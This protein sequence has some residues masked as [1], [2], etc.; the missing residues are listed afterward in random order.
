MNL[1]KTIT[2]DL[3]ARG[4][5]IQLGDSAVSG[6]CGSRALVF[7]LMEE[8]KPWSVPAGTRAGLAFRTEYGA[9]GE[10]D[11]MPDGSEAWLIE[12][13]RVT[14]RLVDAI[15]ARP[16][17]VWLA[18]VLRDEGF[19][20]LS[21]FPVVM[22]VARGLEDVGEIPRNY[23][24]VR[25][26]QEIN[27]AIQA[28]KERVEQVD[29]EEN[30]A[31]SR[32]ARQAVEEAKAYAASVNGEL[33]QA[34]INAKGDDVYVEN[35]RLYLTSNGARLGVGV[36]LP[37]GGGVGFASW[38]YDTETM[39][40]HAR[41]EE[42][43]DVLEPVYI[44]GGSGGGDSGS[45][46]TVAMETS[47]SVIAAETAD[48][49]ELAFSF[50]SVDASTGVATG[51]GTM[52]ISVGGV[53]KKTQQIG[54]GRVSLNIRP[55]LSAGA[56]AV[57]LT[58]TDAYGGRAARNI[59][60]TLETL[61]LEWS[62]GATAKTDDTLTVYLTA[63]GNYTKT[64]HL[65]VDGNDIEVFDVTT[66]GRRVTKTV[67]AQ[68]H[69]G[70]IISAYATMEAAGTTMTSD[71][72]Q[73]ACAWVVDEIVPAI[74]CADVPETADQF[75]TVQLVHRVVDPRNNPAAVQYLVNGVLFK[76]AVI[77]QS[78]QIWSYR[79]N[80]AGETTLSILCGNI[81]HDEVIQVTQLAAGVEEVTD[82]LALKID[83]AAMADL[84]TWEENGYRFA[85]SEGF[86][87]VNG[88]L[89]ND[90]DGVRCIRVTAGDRLKLNY[91]LFATDA[92]ANGLA[93]KL[94]YAVRDSSAKHCTAISCVS[95][96]MGLEIQ[97]NN[98]YLRGNQT[99]C[100]LSVCED[101]KTEL[102]FNIQT[103]TNDGIMYLWEKCSTFAYMKYAADESFTFGG[104]GITFGCD[105]ADV[106]LYLARFYTRDLTD[107][108]RLANYIADGANTAEILDRR[109]RNDIYDS[110]GSIDV[111]KCAAKNP[112]CH[113]I[114][115]SAER[116]TKGKKDEVKANFRHIFK[117][118]GAEHQW[119]ASGSMFVQGTSS[120]EHAET[121]GP[122]LNIYYPD[123]ITLADGT[124]VADGY[125]MNG[126]DK[127]IPVLELC[128]KKNIA[129]E[130]HIVNRMSAEWYNRYQPS[131]R[132]ERAAN[133]LVRDCLDSAM[134]CVYF[135]NS[136]S[137]AVQVGPDLV[138][139]GATIFFGLGNLVSNKD[140]VQAFGYHPIVI[141][142]KNNTEPQVL[143]KSTDLEGSNWGNNYEFRYLDTTKYTEDE[144]KAEWQKVQNF[145][146]ETDCT[147]ATDLPLAEPVT[148]GG[149]A[150]VRDDVK[151]RRARWE[152]ESP[153]IFDK[154]TLTWHHN[155]TLF[156]LL[157]D[158]R[159]K[160]MFWSKDPVTGRWGLWFNWDNDTGLCRNNDGYVDIEPG[161]MDFDTIGTGDVFN[162]A[163]NVVFNNLR[164]WDFAELKAD[165]LDRESA[166][167]WDIDGLYSYAM[168]SQESICEALWIEDAAHN[169]VR[170]MQA[171]GTTAY[172]ERATGRLR[173]HLKKALTFQKVLVDSYY[174]STAATG[175]SAA[176]RGY[177][178]SEWAGVEP[179]G[180]LCVTAYTN[181]YVNVLAG[182]TAYQVRATE[183]VPVE[184]DISASLNN[185]EVYFRHAEWM[186]DLGDLAGLYLG[187][188]EASMLKRVRRLSIGSDNVDYYNT[189]FTQAS[190]DNCRKLEYLNLGGLRNAARSFD[191][192]PNIYLKE[193]Y[194]RGSG[195]TGVTFARQGRL[196]TA[197]LNAV[198]SLA[199]DT[200]T[201]LETFTMPTY[202][203]LTVLSV[204]D[205]PALDTQAMAEGAENLQRVRLIGIDWS[206]TN[207]ET[208]MRLSGCAGRD[209][210][211]R[212]IPA[213]IV[214]G[215]AHIA[216]LT[217]E[218]LTQLNTVFPDLVI[219]YD[220]IVPSYTVRFYVEGTLVYS[221][222]VAQDGNAADPVRK[223]LIPTPT[224][225]SDVEYHYSYTGWDK[226]LQN[227]AADTDFNAVFAAADRCY[228]VRYWLSDAEEHMAQESS[229]IAHGSVVYT[230]GEPVLEGA[231]FIGW[232]ADTADV[233]SDLDL[234]PVFLVPQVPE[235]VVEQFD[236]LYSD[237]PADD[238]A[239]TLAQFAGILDSGRAKE[240]F[241]V[242]DRIKM[243]VPEN[244]TF[245]DE[246][247]I[248]KL[249][250]F[251][252]YRLADGSGA[253]ASAV[254]G[255]VGVMN[256]A[257]AIHDT[258]AS[259]G[260]WP[261][262][263]LR[264]K[265]TG[266]YFSA[267][268]LRWQ[269]LIRP[270]Q[271]RCTV[272]QDLPDIEIC[273]DHLFLLSRAELG[274]NTGETPYKDEIDPEAESVTFPVFTDTASRI[275]R[276]YNGEGEAC[277]YWLRTVP[278]SLFSVVTTEGYLEL[279]ISP[280]KLSICWA[281]CMGV[282][283]V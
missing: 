33:L 21:A 255:M 216:A 10:Y 108:E 83:P 153:T 112:D 107:E 215:R 271:V 222:R 60:V 238:S 227:I 237:D 229:V 55:Y 145:L 72:L 48:E 115:I 250:G 98:V 224:K 262:M 149:V 282:S 94:V 171:F 85:L 218:E 128:Y 106:Y 45:R 270:V 245:T 8:G 109:N 232:D 118:G 15:L 56:N 64:V 37:D 41:D 178:P 71:V 199:V 49:V 19:S 113:H 247:I 276:K 252:H 82:G 197:R 51:N 111:E 129:S 54:Q 265:L 192:R 281:C 68:I 184:L 74:A 70:H 207:A 87:L 18:L 150:F 88:G 27:V 219:T 133:P 280:A 191:F 275:R 246:V 180:Q 169:A 185:T 95:G 157:R 163:A 277:T 102:D 230:A 146:Y 31:A 65:Q 62:L 24:L 203:A 58:I 46:I 81:R 210:D 156:L 217:Q 278:G 168:D 242:G 84:E 254:F 99:A 273:Q 223:G 263:P 35:G 226:S 209:D 32:E 251:N 122:N 127:S 125:A 279:K 202:G 240:Y 75:S 121:A 105:D 200:L 160:N 244:D 76:E 147:A 124:V 148:I 269:K 47:A 61:A 143:F 243:V 233:V 4:A 114:V 142:V 132:P 30:R 130:D 164:T 174:C 13:N 239:Y 67:P 206:C 104:I 101:E 119:T 195:V 86:D 38:D 221:Q 12:G 110:T 90:A 120:V 140:S 97:P 235:T 259:A 248:L 211:G 166:G 161:Y 91:P 220:T 100:K 79:L 158:N 116:M 155:I 162:G 77:D 260:G 258:G 103:D 9:M 138:P 134:C 135:H 11:T 16:G 228:T 196:E 2:I 231:Y 52:E 92:R 152:A 177:T 159:A 194:T 212:D 234:H 137:A 274:W 144:A 17:N 241:Q 175:Q 189:N 283:G 253:F 201:R 6:D 173:L 261:V 3:A 59:S 66:S 205:T 139:P 123:G 80:T 267:L 78:E 136:G 73:C 172:L 179:S 204:E 26:L 43:N 151:Y 165:Y 249:L 131:V 96:G 126:R 36:E 40:L 190:F 53:I 42:G 170:T 236:Y 23:Y 14:V 39:L 187:Q 1:K 117:G 154:K 186:Q 141:E 225:A 20:R 183:G 256:S 266:D 268:P 176:F 44:P 29:T 213:P 193:L 34:Q 69:G 257:A 93:A 188:F 7:E 182:N 5:A 214:T 28:L 25:N 89:T 22:T 272:G 63:T 264:T 198:K 181:M 57:V 50:S 208:L 167:A